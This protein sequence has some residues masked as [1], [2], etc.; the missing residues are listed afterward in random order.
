[1]I[2]RFL[3]GLIALAAAF[4]AAHAQ[5]SRDWSTT[6]AI[7]GVM[8]SEADL[9][10]GGQMKADSLGVRAGIATA[11]TPTFRAGLAL[12]AQTVDYRFSGVAQTPWSD[13][14]RIGLSAP[15]SQGYA[16][17]WVALFNPSIDLIR[18]KGAASSD[19]L[20]WGATL[21]GMK[22]FAIDQRIG[23]GAAVYRRFE[24][25]VA[26]PLLVI[27]WNLGQ[28]WSLANPLTAGP[29]GPAGLELRYQLAPR[30]QAGLG[31]AYRSL[32]FRLDE[33]QAGR[34]G[35]VGIE[36]GI[37][38]FARASYALTQDVSLDFVAGVVT[39]GRLELQNAGGDKL[40]KRDLGTSALGGI[41]LRGSF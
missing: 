8:Q 36:S 11:L 21:A 19:S 7:T 12:N 2:P 5:A 34:V 18:E 30:W 1:M 4:P 24:K 20:V 40:S 39:M 33:G 22:V 37:P 23:F 29:T 25:T 38:V 13:I 28:G 10:G 27:D 17:G 32:A 26:F 35:A 3:P 6:V 41:S 15:M 14:E 9:G 31:A 16:G